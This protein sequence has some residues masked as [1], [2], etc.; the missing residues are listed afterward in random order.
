MWKCPELDLV[1][2]TRSEE[3]PEAKVKKMFKEKYPNPYMNAAMFDYWGGRGNEALAKLQKVRS[4]YE[5]AS[6]HGQVD[7]LIKDV[8]TV[9]QLFKTGSS[10]LN[11]GDVEKAAEPFD[12]AL[13]VDKRVMGPLWE[14][15]PSFYR[16]N[17]QQD[18]A[19]KAYERGRDW[20]KRE[21]QRKA[22]R[23]W[24]TGF[25]FYKGNTDLIR[26]LSNICSTV[27][28]KMLPAAGSCPDLNEV[29]EYAV[30]GDGL[31]EKMAKK[32]EELQCK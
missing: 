16:H 32:R 6:L 3:T 30:Q 24:K 13:E 21:D 7:L 20:S 28:S 9:D 10:L 8:S 11:A 1:T 2:G 4:D 29:E 22:C 25:R 27:G 14:T 31:D 5:K 19:D 18:I 17:I 23:I 12:E 26:V 15:I